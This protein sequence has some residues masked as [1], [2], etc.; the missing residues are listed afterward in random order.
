MKNKFLFVVRSILDMIIVILSILGF[1]N[2]IDYL[3][4]FGLI[5]L[6]TVFNVNFYLIIENES[7]KIKKD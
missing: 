6:I 5:F 4:A 3:I 2:F 1:L 7:D